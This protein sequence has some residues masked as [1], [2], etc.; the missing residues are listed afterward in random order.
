[1]TDDVLVKYLFDKA[2]AESDFK[3]GIITKSA[4]VELCKEIEVAYMEE[5]DTQCLQDS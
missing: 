1:M 2:Q 3:E 5:K 4:M